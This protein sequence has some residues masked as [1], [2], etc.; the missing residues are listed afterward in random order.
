[1]SSSANFHIFL[2]LA[3]VA[4]V[5]LLTRPT[6]ISADEFSNNEDLNK[7]SASFVLMV[8]HPIDLFIVL[9]VKTNFH[10][11]RIRFRS[12]FQPGGKRREDS[13][14]TCE[15]A[16]LLVSPIL[17]LESG[18]CRFERLVPPEGDDE[19]AG[20]TPVPTMLFQSNLVFPQKI[21]ISE[22]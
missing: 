20:A 2:L 7:V 19:K 5:L 11:F 17:E 6:A 16:Y 10:L 4:T 18:I 3:F 8:I 15:T 21:I 1:M 13:A 22:M 14:T 9:L 12:R